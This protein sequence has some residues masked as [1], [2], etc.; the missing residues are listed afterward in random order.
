M[1]T[2]RPASLAARLFVRIML[3]IMVIGLAMAATSFWA[4]R[5]EIDR[6]SDIQLTTAANVLYALM[7]D[8]LD[9]GVE[10]DRVFTFDDRL[11]SGE[12]LRGFRASADWRMFVAWRDGRRVLQSDTA[13]RDLMPPKGPGFATVR[14][15]SG[16][17]RLYNLPVPDARL[18]IQIGERITVRNRLIA[19]VAQNLV[20]PLALLMAGSAVLL[21][22]SLYDGLVHLRRLGTALGRRGPRSTLRFAPGE[23]PR[24]LAPL[25]ITINDLLD[26]VDAAL[27][28]ERQF[29]DDAAHQLRTPLATLKLQLQGLIRGGLAPDR[30]TLTPLLETT[31]RASQLV[32]QMLTL[33]RLEGGETLGGEKIDLAERVRACMADQAP[34]AARRGIELAFDEGDGA[35]ADTDGTAIDLILSNLIENAIKH[36]PAGTSVAVTLDATADRI[37]LAVTDEGPGIAPGERSAAVRRFHR[38][39]EGG[40]GA[41]LG[42]AIV[43]SA[44]ALLGAE[45][46]LEDGPLGRGL[47]VLVVIPR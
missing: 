11:L 9:E 43:A 18:T 7:Q 32:G 15:A 2:R 21:W 14:L 3:L 8:E 13:P 24:E 29:T 46:A 44:V 23:W 19:G 34:F 27:D 45:L 39:G 1:I 6:E 42:L 38:S 37:A 47:R 5:R 10:I 4:A 22:L 41:G 30:S 31:D 17:W 35:I 20:V 36:A 16:Q 25:V 28:R 12:D 33:A 40:S 26:R